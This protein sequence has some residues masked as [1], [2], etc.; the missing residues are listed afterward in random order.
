MSESIE[1]VTVELGTK[2][3]VE[4]KS[5]IDQRMED[6]GI[7]PGNFAALEIGCKLDEGWPAD[8]NCQPSLAEY[9]VVARRLGLQVVLN[10]I[11]LR[12]V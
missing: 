11:E 12:K 8:K 1:I 4:L 6:L 10:N 7:E 2:N 9:V 5:V 3:K